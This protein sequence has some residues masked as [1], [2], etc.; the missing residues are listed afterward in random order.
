MNAPFLLVLA[1]IACYS[2]AGGLLWRARIPAMTSPGLASERGGGMAALAL[3]ALAVAGHAG[4]LALALFDGRTVTLNLS[5]VITLLLFV[6]TL[7][8]LVATL[9][10]PVRNLL[11]LLAPLSAGVLAL[12]ALL[13]TQAAPLGNLSAP[14]VAHI[15]FAIIAYGLLIMA[16][17]QSLLLAYQER[18]LRSRRGVGMMA[19]LPPLQ[20]MERLLFAMLWLGIVVLTLAILTGFAY[21]DNLFAQRVV[22]H[23]VLAC[24]SWVVYAVL[25]IGRHLAGWRGA[26]AVRFTLVGFLLLVLAYLGSKFVI[27]VLLAGAGGAPPA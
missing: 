13:P 3:V 11:L 19:V 26:T 8:V 18:A 27:E 17:G 12:A 15:L 24:L 6:A 20:T 25:L 21:L 5:V 22:H 4:V 14:L 9:F 16:T 2:A 1:T 7:F 10:A 23:T